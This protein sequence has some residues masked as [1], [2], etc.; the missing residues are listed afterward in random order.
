MDKYE[1]GCYGSLKGIA[2]IAKVL[3]GRCRMHYTRVA[4]GKGELSEDLTPK[5]LT[6][7]PEYVMDAMISSVTNPIDGECQVS[8]QINSAN[9]ENG[10]YCTWLILYAEDPDEGE[11]PFTALCLENEP[12]W[13]RP[14]SS[15]VGKLAHFDIIAAVGDVDRVSATIDPD[16][17]MTAAAVKELISAA[18]LGRPLTVPVTGWTACTS[19]E[20]GAG[21]LYLDIPQPD[22]T[23]AMA[24]MLAILPSSM[25]D[26]QECGMLSACQSISGVLR[27]YARREPKA[28]IHGRLTLLRTYSN[29]MANWEISGAALR[30]ATAEDLG[31]VKVKPGSGLTV[32]LDGSLALDAA[33]EEAI[34][35]L[36]TDSNAGN[37]VE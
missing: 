20:E 17:L 36:F 12:E 8:V 5:T 14:A 18:L 26:A 30:P 4:A 33:P 11:V 15:I 7:P 28:E 1:D 37:G 34:A 35:S 6:E 9:V 10:F 2:L 24:P 23:E 13:I 31:G 25:A 16:A 19:E 21:G 29:T 27:V 3:A 32:D 22:C